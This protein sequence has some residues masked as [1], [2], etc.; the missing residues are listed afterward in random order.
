[1]LVYRPPQLRRSSRTRRHHRVVVNGCRSVC[2]DVDFVDSAPSAVPVAARPALHGTTPIGR[3]FLGRTD[4]Q[5]RA[6]TGHVWAYPQIGPESNRI[7]LLG[8]SKEVVS[9]RGSLFS[10]ELDD[11]SIRSIVQYRCCIL[12]VGVVC[13]FFPYIQSRS[14]IGFLLWLMTPCKK[15]NTSHRGALLSI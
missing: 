14:L 10:L 1:M 3:E 4:W 15:N 2:P 6:Q 8:G 9:P 11:F 7:F 12:L 13:C 5:S